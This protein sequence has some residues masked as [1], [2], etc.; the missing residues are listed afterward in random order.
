MK[1]SFF[2][3]FDQ[4]VLER[5]LRRLGNWNHVNENTST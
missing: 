5:G 1:K 3:N 2:V 4:N